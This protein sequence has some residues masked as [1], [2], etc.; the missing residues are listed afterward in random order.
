MDQR[1]PRAYIV[2]T[3]FEQAREAMS[4]SGR[5][6]ERI[7]RGRPLPSRPLREQ[8]G[9]RS[10]ARFREIN[11]PLRSLDTPFQGSYFGNF[12]DMF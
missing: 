9:M 11:A 1:A 12:A 4:E 3:G 5:R 8:R 6:S 10:R 7:R 2:P